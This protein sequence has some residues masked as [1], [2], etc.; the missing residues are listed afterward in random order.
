MLIKDVMTKNPYTIKPGDTVESCA[1]VMVEKKIGGLP[2]VDEEGLLVGMLTE[3]D[4]IGKNAN[5]PHGVGSVTEILGSHFHGVSIE[6]LFSEVKSLKVSEVM[7]SE[8]LV[9]AS[10]D[11]ALTKAVHL[12]KQ[13]NIKR[14]P[15]L[16]GPTLVGIV[17]RSDLLKAML[18]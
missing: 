2:V 17:T 14:L 12:M 7:T 4:F 5:V 1:R 6:K 18:S 9:A 3:S 8:L 10:P 11:M 16:D 15:V 13:H